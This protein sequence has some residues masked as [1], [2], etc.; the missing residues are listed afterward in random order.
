[1][2][3]GEQSFGLRRVID[4]DSTDEDIFEAGLRPVS[5]KDYVGQS[6][7]CDNIGISISAAKRREE[8]L[9][10]VLLH[11]PPGLGKTT[12]AIIIANE[13]GVNLKATSGPVLEKPGDLA[14]ILSSLKE[15]DVLFIDEMHRLPRVVE[16]VLYS[17]MEDFSIDI[18]IG[19]GPAARSVKIKIKPFT[20][21]GCLLYTSDAADEN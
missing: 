15:R 3:D 14:A 5:F 11:G 17:A 4:L 12:L 19:E 8:A 7:V 20:L 16:E 9:D 18:I 6:K 21:I 2:D 10:H 13:L 1:M